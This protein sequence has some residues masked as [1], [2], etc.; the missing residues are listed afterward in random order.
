MLTYSVLLHLA[1]DFNKSSFSN[2]E[3]IIS[4]NI[5]STLKVEIFYNL[6]LSI[7]TYDSL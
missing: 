3:I 7:F 6:L 2:K 1:F 5:Y 4:V